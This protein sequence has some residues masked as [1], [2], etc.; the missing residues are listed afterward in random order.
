MWVA[1]EVRRGGV[2]SRLIKAVETWARSQNIREL[3]LDV[4]DINAPAIELYRKCGFEFT[5]ERHPYPNDPA[6]RELVMCKQ[7]ATTNDDAAS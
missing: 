5:G 6:L 2:A 4:T 7:L 3:S 1:P